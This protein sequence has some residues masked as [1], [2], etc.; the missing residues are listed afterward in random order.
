[1]QSVRQPATRTLE[2]GIYRDGANNLDATQAVTLRQA[3]RSSAADGMVEYTV[4]DTT[5]RG[6][7][8]LPTSSG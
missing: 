6:T 5:S 2:F 1:M 8:T 4:E 7:G 3:M